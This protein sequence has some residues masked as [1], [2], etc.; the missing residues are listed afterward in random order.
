MTIEEGHFRLYTHVSPALK[1]G[2]Y[3]FRAAQSLAAAGPSGALGASDLPVAGLETHVRVT[4]P[5]YQLPA[6][7]VL[8]TYPPAGTEGAY[9][10]RLPQVVIKRRT[11]PWE[12][13][14]AATGDNIPWL[15]LVVFAEGE[16]TVLSN[17]PV[18]DCITAGVH[19]DGPVDVEKG[20]CLEIKSS[21][22]AKIMPTRK[23]VPLLVH[24][25]EVNINDTELMLGDDD[26]FLAVVIANRLPV[27]GRTPKGDEAPVKY[28][29]VL[30]SLEGVGQFDQL[31]PESPPAQQGTDHLVLDNATILYTAAEYDHHIMESGYAVPGGAITNPAMGGPG[32]MPGGLPGGIGAGPHAAGPDAA[33]P[34]AAGA[35]AAKVTA[36][37]TAV[38]KDD[39]AIANSGT[40]GW[41]N[42]ADA[43]VQDRRY[44]ELDTGYYTGSLELFD[45]TVRFP[46]LLHWSFT[47]IGDTTFESL[48]RG[49]D[50]GLLGTRGQHPTTPAGRAPLEVVDDMAALLDAAGESMRHA[51][52]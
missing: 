3:R 44:I 6:D 33:G 22:V 20:A 16:A 48:M 42:A 50:N 49:A 26:G 8:S 46:A 52:D 35:D 43:T 24:A 15:A 25:R 39:V 5:R 9:G 2:D 30:I 40:G 37:R 34:D 17:L 51:G 23:D 21:M 29:A 11:L 31:L 38:A 28:H 47:S 27:A 1:A 13:G 18:A 12:R 7:Q 32:G 19:L 10:S 45:P 36:Y 14:P 41:Q 4:S